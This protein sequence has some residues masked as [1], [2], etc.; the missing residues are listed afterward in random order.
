MRRELKVKE[1]HLQ[2]AARRR[3]QKFQQ[4]Q[5]ETELRRLND[6]IER[7]VY[8]SYL[9]NHTLSSIYSHLNVM[10]AFKFNTTLEFTVNTK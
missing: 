5:C 10:N 2:D 8:Y 1:M 4:S 3:F 6:E 9:S 7:K